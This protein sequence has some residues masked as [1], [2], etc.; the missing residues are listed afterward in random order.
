[1]TLFQI[2]EPGFSP[3][4]HQR[5]YAIGIDLGTTHS[6]VATLR[7]GVALALPDE[8]GRVLLPSVV[9]YMKHGTLVGEDARHA[10]HIDPLNT[11][12]SIK[13]F[14]GRQLL[15]IATPH[16]YP[17]RF[18]SAPGMVQIETVAGPVN[19]VQVSA[20]ILKQLR[21]RAERTLDGELAGAV[22]TVPA[23]FDDAQRQA[24]KDAA[25]LAGLP[26]LRL[27]NEPT[28]A[29]LAYGLDQKQ[30]GLFGVYDLGGGTFDFSVL[31]LTRGV[32]EVLATSGDAALG[33]DDFDECILAWTES[34]LGEAAATPEQLRHRLMQCRLAKETLS[35]QDS[36]HLLLERAGIPNP[37]VLTRNEFYERTRHLVEYTFKPMRTALKDARVDLHSLDGVVLVGGATRMKHLQQMVR[38]YFACPVLTTLDPDCAVALGAAHQ[39]QALLDGQRGEH[40]LLLDVIPLSLGLETMGG[41]VEKIIPRNTTIPVTRAQEFTTFKDGQGAMRIHIVQGERELVSECRSLAHFDLRGIPPM[42]AGA[43]RIRVTFQVDADGLLAVSARE[44]HTGTQSQVSVKPTYGLQEGEILGMLKA[45]IS[46]AAQDKSLRALREAQVETRRLLDAVLIALKEDGHGLLSKT[47]WQDIESRVQITTELL[48]SA[49]G[50]SVHS[51]R[52]ACAALNEA[53][54]EFAARRMNTSIARALLGQQIQQLE[55]PG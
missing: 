24:T 1:M 3:E 13:R 38:D 32:F 34:Q 12:V 23:Y 19:P 6:L 11:L 22:I 47:E 10:A 20:E 5:R 8:Q 33:G 29:A 2:A 43:A 49:P 16:R 46:E 4:P 21:Q 26:V 36:A 37:L 55:P 14:M 51:L 53:T 35:K 54:Q 7:S 39:A 31:R 17:Y 15:D 30:E 18:S 40:S 45:G 48:E 27:L 25:Q 52:A 42:V 44:Q 41:L 9:R 28:A 50:G